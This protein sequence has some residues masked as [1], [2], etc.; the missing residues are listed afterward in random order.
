MGAGSL[1][2]CSRC[3]RLFVKTNKDLCPV[4]IKEIEDEYIRCAE[5]LREH[6]LVSLY[7]LSEATEV[8]VKQITRFIKE[9][10]ISVADF[11]NISYTCESCG[12]PIR[13]G[14]LC[15]KCSERLNK[16][17]KKVLEKESS[18]ESTERVNTYYQIKERFNK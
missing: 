12:A 13:E 3:D 7:E 8:S 1:A 6:K 17:I 9:G 4:C 15:K 11:P 5:Y 18:E 14:K 10:R 16:D 2:N